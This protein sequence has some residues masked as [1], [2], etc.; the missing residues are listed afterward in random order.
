M[1]KKIYI[2]FSSDSLYRNSIFL[3]ANTAIMAIIGFVFWVIASRLYT[4]EQIGTAT[5]MLASVNLVLG[6][7]ILGFNVVLVRYLSTHREPE[8]LI[9]TAV[10]CVGLV[11]LFA[12]IIYTFGIPVFASNLGFILNNP[13]YII[14]F[15]CAVLIAALNTIFDTLFIASR[16]SGYSLI[17]GTLVSL[18][19]ISLPFGLV[20][21]GGIGVFFSFFISSILGFFVNLFLIR[22]VLHLKIRPM[23]DLSVLR[24]VA[25]FSGA[26]YVAS[27]ISMLPTNYIPIMIAN[28]LGAQ[29]A[30]YFYMASM[31]STVLYIVPR[32]TTQS[33]FAEGSHDEH[34]VFKLLFRAIKLIVTLYIPIIIIT[35]IFG[36]HVLNFFGKEYSE[37]AF[38]LLQILTVSGIFYATNV[39]LTTVLNVRKEVGKIIF[40]NVIGSVLQLVVTYFLVRYGL[41]TVGLGLMLCYAVTTVLFII[42]VLTRTSKINI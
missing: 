28:S 38:H 34:A 26:N 30:A 21:F 27:F 32:A 42:L 17:V 41:T 14:A 31:I 36:N 7:C 13:L 8:R 24:E 29:E 16:K 1:L 20:S 5:T 37:E 11:S 40:I 33:L 19:K 23:L 9:G 6:F 15:I 4:S 35:V 22:T 2:H 12:A 39:L 25:K 18:L 3:I 10:L